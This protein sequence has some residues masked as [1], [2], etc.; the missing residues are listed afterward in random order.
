LNTA[1][2]A[3]LTDFGI[4][5]ILSNTQFTTT[6]ALVGTPAYMSP[7]QGQGLDLSPAS[8]VYSLGV[9]LYE[10]LTGQ[11]PFDADTPIAFI[12]KHINDPL[13]SIRSIR[14]ELP[15]D[16]E[17]VINK[18]LAKEPGQR[19]QS[20]G[21]MMG[22]LQGVLTQADSYE[23][24]LLSPQPTT[25]LTS[26]GAPEIEKGVPKLVT[27]IA[28][29]VAVEE[30]YFDAP[31][32]TIA[33]E[34]VPRKKVW[35][36]SALFWVGGIVLAAVIVLGLI[37]FNTFTP[38]AE[39]EPADRAVVATT[40]PTRTPSSPEMPETA[41]NPGLAQFER[42]MSFFH[43]EQNYGEAISQFNQAESL[44][45]MD[46]ELYF[47]RAW[48][49]HESQFYHGKCS[50][51]DALR[52]FNRAIE[53]DPNQAGYYNGRAMV[54]RHTENWVRA[55]EDY[56]RAIELEPDN[57]G[58][59][60]SRGDVFGTIGEYDRALD[61]I[62]HGIDMNPNEP[63]FYEARG[64]IHFNTGDPQVAAED[65]S[66]AI[67]LDPENPDFWRFRGRVH[68][69]M[70]RLD[71][72]LADY[73]QAIDLNPNIPWPYVGRANVFA[74]SGDM[75]AAIHNL[76]LAIGVDPQN[77]RLYIRRAHLFWWDI[78][79]IDPAVSDLNF[80]ID[81]NPENWEPYTNLGEIY[82]Y[83]FNDLERGLEY[84]N[85]AISLAPPEVGAPYFGRGMYYSHM[86][87]WES[88]IEDLTMAIHR[89]PEGADA[90]GH[91]GFAY[92]E[93]GMLDEARADYEMFLALT[94]GNPEYAGWR[95][96]VER[97]MGQNP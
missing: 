44:G 91:R 95:E 8:D 24:V 86:G 93:L 90:F 74:E 63:Y 62:S 54:Y 72:A 21:E 61:D 50:Y 94:E 22:A 12:F 77:D 10:F 26:V 32:E 17:S 97:W 40:R 69:N 5:R 16:L 20:P 34:E 35:Y 30:E 89:H 83:E 96:E 23:T 73:T 36:Q 6:G 64:W 39:D 81:L 3:F 51:E 19:F 71:D 84:F 68:L 48:A 45:F 7:E 43:D 70:G 58:H 15:P 75:D 1:G 42:G 4:A 60:V 37:L 76:N 87:N 29:T 65:F 47:Q 41:E 56:S 55:I 57:A 46:P 82:T 80:A 66:R 2:D 13:P 31:A 78:G 11:V 14:P 33:V 59:W 27:P 88:A 49:C 79:D 85:Q 28:P 67:E 9:M 18:S 53:L 92:Q 38:W 52:D 25:Q